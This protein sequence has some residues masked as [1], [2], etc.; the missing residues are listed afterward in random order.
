MAQGRE[1]ENEEWKKLFRPSGIENTES[2]VVEH[3]QP[4]CLQQA[5]GPR[6]LRST[7][8]LLWKLKTAIEWMRG[9]CRRRR[10]IKTKVKQ[11]A[12]KPLNE[13]SWCIELKCYDDYDYMNA[14]GPS[15]SG[16]ARVHSHFSSF[17]VRTKCTN[18]VDIGFMLMCFHQMHSKRRRR[19]KPAKTFRLAIAPEWETSILKNRKRK[20][21]IEGRDTFVQRNVHVKSAWSVRVLNRHDSRWNFR[22][23]SLRNWPSRLPAVQLA[24]SE[25]E[26]CWI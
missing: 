1:W 19:P 22:R 21:M 16:R 8:R 23:C 11:N 9:N 7:F 17:G 15:E 26:Y 12:L 13:S 10:K 25:P 6:I 3:K 24:Q 20:R 18:I 4:T 5:A 14:S 2:R